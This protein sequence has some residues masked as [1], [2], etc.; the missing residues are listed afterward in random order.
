MA[1]DTQPRGGGPR[2]RFPPR[3]LHKAEAFIEAEEGAVNRL[4]G[5]A[6][7][8]VTGSRGGDVAVPPLCRGRRRLAV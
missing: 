4:A 3:H 6:G 1:E 5:W 8:L 7:N 2:R